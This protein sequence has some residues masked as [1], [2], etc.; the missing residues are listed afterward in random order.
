M[1]WDITPVPDEAAYASNWWRIL[2]VDAS[3]GVAIAAVGVVLALTWTPLAWAL[4]PLGAYYEYLVLKRVA[5][6]RALRGL[7]PPDQG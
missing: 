4:V 1:V 2:L 3:I 6:W 7:R 5:R